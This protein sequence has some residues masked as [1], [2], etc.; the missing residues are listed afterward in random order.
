MRTNYGF[1]KEKDII[2][3]MMI[4]VEMI[5]M[6]KKHKHKFSDG[7]YVRYCDNCDAIQDKESGDI[8]D[9]ATAKYATPEDVK[10][11]LME[12]KLND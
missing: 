8:I 7:R 3:H 11:W 1:V 2:V 6:I 10:E 4:G 5:K 12:D 9:L